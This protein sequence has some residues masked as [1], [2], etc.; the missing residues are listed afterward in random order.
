MPI[1]R[2]CGRALPESGAAVYVATDADL[3]NRHYLADLRGAVH[4]EGI[5]RRM[6]RDAVADAIR[7]F[8]GT[9][10]RP[11]GTPCPGRK[12]RAFSGGFWTAS[13]FSICISGSGIRSLPHG[14][15]RA[16]RPMIMFR[17]G[18]AKESRRRFLRRGAACKRGHDCYRVPQEMRMPHILSLKYKF[19]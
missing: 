10:L 19:S 7:D 1:C 15:A 14:S 12:R 3:H 6:W 2:Y 18:S 9:I 16:Y 8:E 17:R 5:P 4:D 11:D 13:A